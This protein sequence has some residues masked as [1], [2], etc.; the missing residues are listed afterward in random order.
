MTGTLDSR[1]P[2]GPLETRWD[3]HKGD[4]K[5]VSPANKDRAEH[6]QAFVSKCETYLHQGVGLI[7]VDIVT[8]RTAN[9]H[10]ELMARLSQ[11]AELS[12]SGHLYASAY[13]VVEREQQPQLDIWQETLSVGQPLPTMPLWLRGIGCLPVE[14]NETYERTC[15]ELK[16]APQV[17]GTSLL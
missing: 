13:C 7:V 1:S 11:T 5:L 10:N 8:E 16:I 2:T 15:R 12:A 4:L 17:E 6:R 3:R 14:L 9:L